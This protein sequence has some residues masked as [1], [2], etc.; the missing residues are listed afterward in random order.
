MGGNRSG[1]IASK[2][3]IDSFAQLLQQPL[4]DSLDKQFE[5][6][7][8]QC[9]IADE[10][11]RKVAYSSFHTLGMGTTIISAII[12]PSTCIHAYAGDSRLYHFRHHQIAYQSTDNTIVQLLVETGRITPEDI[13]TH[14]MRSTLT[15]CL[16]GKNAE[17]KFSVYPK[18]QEEKPVTI[19]FKL[20]DSLLLCSDG[21]TNLVD[22]KT[23]ENII[24]HDSC[25]PEKITKLMLENALNNGEKIIL[26][27]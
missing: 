21:L 15:S 10:E 14:P 9:Y 18:L 8:K 27:F 17:G 22:N 6:L 1:E 4:P 24:N 20:S 12:T 16:G 5:M 19:D 7:V 26:R 13:P 2:I 3:A 11:I 25:N 23:L